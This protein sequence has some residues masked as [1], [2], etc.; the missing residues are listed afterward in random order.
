[1]VLFF[2]LACRLNQS[3]SR[4][5]EGLSHSQGVVKYFW[6]RGHGGSSIKMKVDSSEL[7]AMQLVNETRP[8]S[9]SLGIPRVMTVSVQASLARICVDGHS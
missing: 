3:T 2:T 5:E 4:A 8:L 6:S 1:M 9:K 7:A